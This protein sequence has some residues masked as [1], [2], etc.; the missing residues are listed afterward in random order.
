MLQSAIEFRLIFLPPERGIIPYR[1]PD[2]TSGVS[3]VI[4]HNALLK[5]L[6]SGGDRDDVMLIELS[7]ITFGPVQLERSQLQRVQPK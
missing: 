7:R 1:S 3:P 2:Q 5:G 4:Q 6:P